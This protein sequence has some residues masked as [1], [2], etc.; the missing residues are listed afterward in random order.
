MTEQ[1]NP[2]LVVDDDENNRD[3]LS[4]RLQRAGF[5][6]ETA[7]SGAEALLLIK[8]HAYD[9]VLLDTMMPGMTGTAVL[10]L[11][12]AAH[13]PEDLPVIMVTALTES[14]KI[15]EAIGLGA[16]D[17]VTKPVDYPVALARIKSQLNRKQAG[18]QLREREQR[19]ALAA[20]GSSDGMWDWDLVSN[21]IFYCFRWKALTGH[22]EDE[23]G[24]SPE[25][26]FSRVPPPE[27]REL[28]AAIRNYIDSKRESAFEFEHRLRHKNGEYR[29]VLMRGICAWDA[30]G[31]AVRMAGSAT[32]VTSRK[33]RDELTG[34]ANRLEFTE[35]LSQMLASANAIT[36]VLVVDLDR[37][38]LINDSLGRAAG[39]ALIRE[40]GLRLERCV[41]GDGHT[42]CI[43][44]R[45]SGDEFCCA[46]HGLGAE[47]DVTALAE[48]I[49]REF[50][51]PF[52]L[53]S[54]EVYCTVSIGITST[55]IGA[56]TA[57]DI[58]R[59][60]HI[61]LVAAKT[62]GKGRWVMFEAGMRYRMQSRLEMEGDL[63]TAV[64]DGQLILQYQP[65][66][67]LKTRRVYGFEALVRWNHPGKGLIAPMEFIPLAEETGLIEPIGSW[68]LRQACVDIR[69]WNELY[70]APEPLHVCVN[71]SPK[72]L[73]SSRLVEDTR[74]ILDETGVDP[75]WIAIEIT[76]GSL[77]EDL[78]LALDSLLDLKSLGV[79]LKI[80]DFGTGYSGLNYLHQLPFDTLKID[81]SFVSGLNDDPASRDMIRSIVSMAHDLKMDVIAEGIEEQR[82]LDELT[83]ARTDFG[84]G[85]YFSRPLSVDAAEGL[86][87]AERRAAAELS[88]KA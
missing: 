51:S 31:K 17:Y 67:D 34:L 36:A 88:P 16:N 53:D 33:T 56:T 7:S 71:M 82:Q 55:A 14:E 79:G 47:P 5:D 6:V 37:F 65:I 57:I 70:P 61:A 2:L 48:R 13:S 9:L 66:I 28:E 50:R 58:Q 78:K 41:R 39:D 42:D 26:W 81:R 73:H 75:A 35:R 60:A 38:K 46:I 43:T 40:A 4:R 76:E 69:R 54:Q 63:R 74:R 85:Y 10:K 84:Q 22:R 24:D 8:D 12:R 86:L 18:V 72:Q 62:Q 27:R 11:L 29:W 68:V 80:D 87:K 83:I 21:R 59:D 44:A 15:V 20:L 19:L 32:D 3:M 49:L 45:S 64:A 25:E 52:F 77:F 30:S 1:Q 23:I